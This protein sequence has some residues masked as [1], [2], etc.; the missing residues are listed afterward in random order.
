MI[1]VCGFRQEFLNDIADIE[2]DS[3]QNPW[4]KSMLSDSVSNSNV[5]F[6]IILFDGKVIG[7]CISLYCGIELEI[8]SIA[9]TKE[10]RRKGNAAVLFKFVLSDAVKKGVKSAFLEVGKSNMTAQNFYKSFEFELSS[11]RKK[12]YANGEDALVLRKQ[13]K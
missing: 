3:F 10:Q 9:V 5:S 2:K 11:I 1:E 6:D 7:Y 13:L 4:S 12:Y 8:L